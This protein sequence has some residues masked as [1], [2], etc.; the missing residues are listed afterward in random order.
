MFTKRSGISL[1]REIMPRVKIAELHWQEHVGGKV[2]N[3][4]SRRATPF[5][6]GRAN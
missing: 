5:P 2:G 4:N 3:R 6:K 1:L